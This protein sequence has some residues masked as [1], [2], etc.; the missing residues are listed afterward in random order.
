MAFEPETKMVTKMVPW[1]GLGGVNVHWMILMACL[2]TLKVYH[3]LE[4]GWVVS[5]CQC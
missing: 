4:M 1:P 5:M 3:T 2:V